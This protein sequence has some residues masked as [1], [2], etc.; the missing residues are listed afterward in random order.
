MSELYSHVPYTAA[1]I[2]SFV[3]FINSYCRP[4]CYYYSVMHVP[5]MPDYMALAFVFGFIQIN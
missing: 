4:Y 1:F 5:V 3:V 2:L